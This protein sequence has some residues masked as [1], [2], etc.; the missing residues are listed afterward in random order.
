MCEIYLG[1]LS[2]QMTIQSSV[3]HDCNTSRVMFVLNA[4]T[5]RLQRKSV[6]TTSVPMIPPYKSSMD[7]TKKV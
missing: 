2:K 4:K 6:M 5:G 3:M 7:A 1:L